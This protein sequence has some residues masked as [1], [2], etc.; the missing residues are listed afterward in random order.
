MKI[1]P[2]CF[3]SVEDNEIYCPYCDTKL[4]KSSFSTT[5]TVSN[6]PTNNSYSSQTKPLIFNQKKNNASKLSSLYSILIQIYKVLMVLTGIAIVI[7]SVAMFVM[8]DFKNTPDFG[9]I[10]LGFVV[11]L[12][13][14]AITEVILFLGL[15]IMMMQRDFYDDFCLLVDELE[16]EKGKLKKLNEYIDQNKI[17]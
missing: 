4:A 3:K 14:A 9:A 10:F 17:K 5:N 6:G 12:I 13:A 11:G 2:N 16:I 15:Y 1:C 7:A 8:K